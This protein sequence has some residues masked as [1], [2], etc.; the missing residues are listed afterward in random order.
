MIRSGHEVYVVAP[1]V[2]DSDRYVYEGVSVF[3]YSISGQMSKNVCKGLSAPDGLDNFEKIIMEIAPDIIHFHTFN[4]IVN[5][6]H[7]KTAK[8]LGIKTVFTPHQAGVFCPKGSLIAMSGQRCNGNVGS[9]PCTYCYLRDKGL[10]SVKASVLNVCG[11]VADLVPLFR[12]MEPAS[13]FVKQTRLKELRDIQRYADKVIAIS[14]WVQ[15]TLHKNGVSNVC[16]VRQGVD[17]TLVGITKIEKKPDN[18]L[19]LIFVGRIYPI[20]SLETLCAA[21]EEIDKDRIHLTMA[22]VC[23]KDRYAA[24]IK[25][26]V[27]SL[28]H[29][30]WMENVP[31]DRLGEMLSEHDILVLPSISEMSPLVILEAFAAGIPVLASSI[32][33]VTDLVEDGK[34]GLTFPVKDSSTLAQLLMR[35]QNEPQLVSALKQG[36]RAPRTFTEVSEELENVYA[37]L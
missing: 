12:R 24:R 35:L 33:P 21:L 9:N 37:S 30:S 16:L 11:M 22:C 18:I 28:P 3:R 19:R 36:V 1:R 15:D 4:T 27:H 29:F 26:F 23:G 2:G 31:H 20:K 32:P 34:N 6:Y 25:D 8:K 10:S 7:L 14:P 5:T 17:K 13:L